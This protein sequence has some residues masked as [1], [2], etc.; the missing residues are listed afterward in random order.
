MHMVFISPLLK[1]YH[2]N[3]KNKPD[4]SETLCNYLKKKLHVRSRFKNL[5]FNL[6]SMH[7]NF[8]FFYFNN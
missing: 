1:K 3:N 5:N 8:I 7:I 2:I 6:K 4:K